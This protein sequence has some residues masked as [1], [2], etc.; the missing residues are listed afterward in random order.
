[1]EAAVIIQIEVS[2]KTTFVSDN[3]LETC[4]ICAFLEAKVDESCIVLI[5]KDYN[6]VAEENLVRKLRQQAKQQCHI[7][8][9]DA[10][11]N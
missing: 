1:M 7:L 9:R 11:I 4:Q 5:K 3:S 10:T 2:M 6:F 8:S